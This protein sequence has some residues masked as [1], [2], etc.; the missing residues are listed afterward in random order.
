[1]PKPNASI[2]Y[3]VG[4]QQEVVGKVLLAQKDQHN[5]KMLVVLQAHEPNLGI[6]ALKDYD[7]AELN[8][9]PFNA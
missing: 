2:V 6:L 7:Y 5:C 1:V 3:L 9:L 4:E 8:L